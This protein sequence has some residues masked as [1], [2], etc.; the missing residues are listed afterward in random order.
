[1]PFKSVPEGYAT[2]QSM[3]QRCL[4]KSHP[5]YSRYGGRGISVCEEWIR[6]F[7]SFISDVGARPSSEYTLDRIDNNK[8]YCKE[9]CRWAT[10]REQ[11]INRE[12]NLM[13]TIGNERKLACEVAKEVGV[14]TDTIVS[15]Y[16]RGLGPEEILS[17]ERLFF[18]D[19]L[20]LGGAANGKRQKSKSHC[21]KGHEYSGDNLSTTPQGWRVCKRCR[22]D[23]EARRRERKRL[24]AISRE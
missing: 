10:K 6:S 9:N 24:M 13:V 16:E 12:C 17:K 20:A 1:M 23:K 5:S 21:K 22:A 15:R 11:A 8:G 2:W 3:K 18:K 7:D 19:G 4:N 14:K